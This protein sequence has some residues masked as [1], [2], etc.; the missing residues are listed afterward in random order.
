MKRMWR[1]TAV[2]TLKNLGWGKEIIFS[3]MLRF[4]GITEASLA[5][6]VNHLF[7][8]INPTVA[9]YASKGEV[10]LRVA[11]KAKSEA[12]A[13]ETIEPVVEEIISIAGSDYFGA[14]ED[15]LASVV[16]K[17]LRE[18]GETIAVAESC[19]GGGIGE[20][21]TSIAG[22]SLYFLGGIIAY[23]NRLKT[24]LL[25]VDRNDLD[26]FGAVSA[27]VAEQM[28][29]GVKKLIQTDWAISITGI[30]GPD[31]GTESKPVGLVYVGL[32]HPDGSVESFELR[33]GDRERSLIRYLSACDAIDKLR[34][35]L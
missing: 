16:G 15:T 14:D 10:R 30:A 23:D 22:S 21:F 28:A 18:R 12:E 31:G 6:K 4:R 27:T 29:L 34:R 8:S 13:I 1:E 11:A 19:T 9:P 25:G 7:D 17:R 5:V 33:W 20:M 35:K 3:K 2:P 32:A 26:R 24:S